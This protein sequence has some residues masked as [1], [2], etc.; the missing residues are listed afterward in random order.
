MF[1]AFCYLVLQLFRGTRILNTIFISFLISLSFLSVSV[2]AQHQDIW[3]SSNNDEVIISAINTETGND[4]PV[5]LTTGKYLFTADFSDLGQ[6]TKGTDDPGFNTLDGTFTPN[7]ILNYRVVGSLSFWDGVQWLGNVPNQ[8]VIRVEDALGNITTISPDTITNQVGAIDMV[9]N[10]GMVHQ[11]VEFYID[12]LNSDE[13]SPGIYM[14]EL[15]CFV[16]DALGG[17]TIYSSSDSV[18]IA[19]NYLIDES[20]FNTAISALTDPVAESVPIPSIFIFISWFL[21]TTIGY[22]SLRRNK[23][24]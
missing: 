8:E 17:N 9:S 23:L 2:S 3:L 22:S 16:T 20:G 13:P 18:R 11:H 5:D 19:L 7:S 10:T 14:F 4:V 24:N 6:G 21:L 15:E 12:N 1:W